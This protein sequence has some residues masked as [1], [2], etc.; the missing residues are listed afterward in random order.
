VG[1]QGVVGSNQGSFALLYIRSFVLLSYTNQCPLRECSTVRAT[2][3][4]L[5]NS[6]SLKIQGKSKE[7]TLRIPG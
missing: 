2:L 6:F 3:T 7:N 1:E 5:I 4:V